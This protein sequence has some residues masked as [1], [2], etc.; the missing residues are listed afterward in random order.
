MKASFLA[1]V[2][3]K[4]GGSKALFDRLVVIRPRVRAVPDRLGG[5]PVDIRPR[6]VTA[7]RLLEEQP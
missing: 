7:A 1:G 3:P 6:F 4:P 5:V 2:G